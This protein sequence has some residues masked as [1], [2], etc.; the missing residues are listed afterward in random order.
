VAEVGVDWYFPIDGDEVVTFADPER[1]HG[2]LGGTDLHA[3]E[4]WLWERHEPKDEWGEAVAA[5][6]GMRRESGAPHRQ[7]FRALPGLR[8]KGTH[9]GYVA[10]NPAWSDQSWDPANPA[11]VLPDLQLW[12]DSTQGLEYALNVTD[13]LKVEH[14][15]SHRDVA[16]LIEAKTY[17]ERRDR[18]GIE[19]QHA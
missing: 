16:R 13:D 7:L 14:R 19:A 8:V 15:R 11:P 18:A 4:L 2:S 9:Y 17:Y 5:Q 3:A 12:G 10:P 1:L 6:F